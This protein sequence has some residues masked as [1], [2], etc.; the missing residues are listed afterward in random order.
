MVCTRAKRKT[1]E[2][3]LLGGLRSFVCMVPE[4][5]V[6]PARYRYHRIL[7]PARLPIPSFRRKNRYIVSQNQPAV[8]SFFHLAVLFLLQCGYSS[9]RVR[10][11]AWGLLEKN[12][13]VATGKPDA[14]VQ[15]FCHAANFRPQTPKNFQKRYCAE[16]GALF[17]HIFAVVFP[18]EP[19]LLLP[20]TIETPSRGPLA[21]LYGGKGSALQGAG[22]L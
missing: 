6:E 7:S 22:E 8:K 10:E 3:P 19:A 15:E 17:C 14:P 9:G 20:K 4:A 2:Q 11:N 1:P 5:G 12:R 18:E 16:F 13:T 21:P